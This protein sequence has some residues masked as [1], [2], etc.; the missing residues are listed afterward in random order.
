M[1]LFKLSVAVVLASIFD[2]CIFAS[3]LYLIWGWH[4]EQLAGPLSYGAAVGLSCLKMISFTKYPESKEKSLEK[5]VFGYLILIV[6]TGI[7]YLA[8]IV[9]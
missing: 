5:A 1:K 7:A 9:F 3:S 2:V 6:F 8:S 4:L